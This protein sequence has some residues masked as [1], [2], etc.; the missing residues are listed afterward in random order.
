MF[1]YNCFPGTTAELRYC[2]IGWMAMK[3][4]IFTLCLQNKFAQPC[5]DI[6]QVKGAAEDPSEWCVR[7]GDLQYP[8]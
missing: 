8:V 7:L 2:S 3:P 6:R 4:R 5:V 1:V